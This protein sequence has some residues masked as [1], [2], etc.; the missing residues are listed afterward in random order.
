[1]EREEKEKIG[2]IKGKWAIEGWERQC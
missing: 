1:M 2:G